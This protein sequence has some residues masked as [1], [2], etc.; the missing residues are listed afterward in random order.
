MA[1]HST[2]RKNMNSHAPQF[3]GGNQIGTWIRLNPQILL[4]IKVEEA[5]RID[6]AWVEALQTVFLGYFGQHDEH[7]REVRLTTEN[8]P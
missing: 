4:R 1:L 8:P 7:E 6:F 5:P 3:S 2:D